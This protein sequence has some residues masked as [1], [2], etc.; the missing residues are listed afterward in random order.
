MVYTHLPLDA[1]DQALY[2]KM[3]KAIEIRIHE[4]QLHILD[5][6]F[7]IEQSNYNFKTLA[8]PSQEMTIRHQLKISR[9]YCE[10]ELLKQ[11]ERLEKYNQE[12]LLADF[13][14]RCSGVQS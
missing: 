6:L 11:D 10:V 3:L 13:T 12:C 14:K 8:Q 4:I 9:M 2:A 1:K 7:Q 5:V